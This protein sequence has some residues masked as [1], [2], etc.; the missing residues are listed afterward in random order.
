MLTQTREIKHCP[1][2]HHF[3]KSSRADR[4]NQGHQIFVMCRITQYFRKHHKGKKSK[5][6]YVKKAF[7][8]KSP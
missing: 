5:N 4:K 7:P 3:Q 8:I 2:N 1:C 6:V